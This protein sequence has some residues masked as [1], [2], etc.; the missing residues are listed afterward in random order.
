MLQNNG[1]PRAIFVV[2]EVQRQRTQE[3]LALSGSCGL[4]IPVT[5]QI[6]AGH[7]AFFLWRTTNSAKV[8][9]DHSAKIP[10]HL[11]LLLAP[12][13]FFLLQDKD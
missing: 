2:L 5:A 6:R 10:T 9:V 7:G 8:S 1:G 4:L 13:S 11:L 3:H 12:S